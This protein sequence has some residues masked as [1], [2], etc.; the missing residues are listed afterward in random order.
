[1]TRRTRRPWPDIVEWEAIVWDA[2]NLDASTKL[3]ALAM[4]EG[5]RRGGFGMSSNSVARWTGVPPQDVD[6][7]LDRLVEARL[8][9]V[10]QPPSGH[11]VTYQ[12]RRPHP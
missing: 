1:M 8:L 2:T 4:A 7:S 6:T 10:A 5:I 3:V 12:L 9:T 11:T